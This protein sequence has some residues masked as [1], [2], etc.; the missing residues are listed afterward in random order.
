MPEVADREAEGRRPDGRPRGER[1]GGQGGPQAPSGVDADEGA[2]PRS[3]RDRRPRRRGAEARR[4]SSSRSTAASSSCPTSTRCCTRRGSPRARSST[5]TPASPRSM[6]PHLR[7]RAL[8]FR[9]FPNGTDTQGLL[10]EALPGAP[11]GVGATSPSGPATARAASSTA[12][13]RSRRRWC[14]RRTWRRSSC[15][16]RWRWPPTS[17]RRGPS[18]STS[19]PG[20]A[21]T[22]STA[23]QSRC[24]VRDV[25]GCGRARGV[26]QDVGLEGPAAVRAAEHRRR[27]ARARRP[28]SPSPSARCSSGSCPKQVTTVMA[29][30]AAAGEDLRR[31]EPE[32]PPQDDDRPVLAA[33]PAGADGVDAGDVG[34]GRGVRRPATSSCASRPPT[35]SNGSTSSATCSRRC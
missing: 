24:A 17:T 10:R 4:R 7:G 16:P 25:L 33:G 19:I 14:G 27:H 22:S 21:P 5:T 1:R 26:V 31:L 3:R 30:V 35:C 23:A 32:R 8:T 12:A 2:R 20:R 6:L 9:R 29:K 15:T 11:A 28:T 34:R 18:C 13:S